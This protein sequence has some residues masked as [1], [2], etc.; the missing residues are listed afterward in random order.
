ML[1]F[2]AFGIVFVG[3]AMFW[4]FLNHFLIDSSFR[5]QSAYIVL[6]ALPPRASLSALSS[7]REDGA[8]FLMKRLFCC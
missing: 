2:L 1:G 7:K 4:N 3:W 6:C 8:V 5:L